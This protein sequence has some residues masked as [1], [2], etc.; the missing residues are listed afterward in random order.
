MPFVFG[1]HRFSPRRYAFRNE[2]C[3]ACNAVR[4]AEGIV[5]ND[6]VHVFW[7]PLIPIGDHAVWSCMTCGKPPD[8]IQETRPGFKVA[9]VLLLAFG[10]VSLWATPLSAGDEVFGWA[11]RLGLPAG[12]VASVVHLVRHRSKGAR[13]EGVEAVTPADDRDCPF[14][15][16]PLVGQPQWHCATCGV[17][18]L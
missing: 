2:M 10:T 15:K 8:E 9:G 11:M 7:I 5:T 18:R 14:C 1:R 3:N 17:L 12:L 13:R 16:V 4:R 6:F